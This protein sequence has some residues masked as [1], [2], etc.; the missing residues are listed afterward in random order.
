M[1]RNEFYKEQIEVYK[2]TGNPSMSVDVVN[3]LMVNK[4][5]ELFIQKR[6]KDKN[7]NPR[8]LDKSL[9]GHVRYGDSIDFTVMIETVQELQVPSIVLKSNK[10][11]IKNYNLLKN[12]VSIVAIIKHVDTRLLLMPKVFGKEKI[13]IADNVYFF[14]GLY[15]GRTKTVDREATGVLNYSLSDLEEEIEQNPS[16]FADDLAILLEKYKTEICDFIK[17]VQ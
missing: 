10:D 6:S 17:E 16:I 11:F 15:D 9:G 12:Y 3:I 7:H 14:L 13:T 5:G 8:L 1:S 4:E 2:K